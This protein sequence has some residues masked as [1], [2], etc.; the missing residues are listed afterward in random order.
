LYPS[1]ATQSVLPAALREFTACPPHARHTVCHFSQS[2]R[3]DTIP[4]P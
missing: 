3:S 4:S 1:A 2:L